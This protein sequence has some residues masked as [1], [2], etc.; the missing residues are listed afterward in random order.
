ML[1]ATLWVFPALLVIL[2]APRIE[3]DGVGSI[4]GSLSY[5]IIWVQGSALVLGS[6]GDKAPS[7]I[8]VPQRRFSP[9]APQRRCWPIVV[10]SD[11]LVEKTILF[12]K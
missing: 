8:L 6:G 2:A 7:Y 3:T 1:S 4:L 11:K 9:V 12:K 10:G 5:L